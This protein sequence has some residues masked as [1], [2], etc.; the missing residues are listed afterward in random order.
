MA[1]TCQDYSFSLDMPRILFFSFASCEPLKK[2]QS[3]CFTVY[4]HVRSNMNTVDGFG[5]ITTPRLAV[6]PSRLAIETVKSS[7]S[8]TSVSLAIVKAPLM[9]E[10]T[11]T[12]NVIAVDPGV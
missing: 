6:S 3:F 11:P 2:N 1:G 12:A 8:S 9:A 7:V 5:C 10:V 4:L